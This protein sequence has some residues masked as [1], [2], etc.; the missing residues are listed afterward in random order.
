MRKGYTSTN[1]PLDYLVDDFVPIS[2]LQHYAFCERQCALIHVEQMWDDNELTVEGTQLHARVDAGKTTRRTAGV[3]WRSVFVRSVT[4]GVIGIV[5]SVE[6]LEGAWFPVE[7]KRGKRVERIADDVQ[8]CA[9]AVAL[10]EMFDVTIESGAVVYL[11]SQRRRAVAFSE[12]LR[13][14]TAAV[15][16][17]VHRVLAEMRTPVVKPAPRC[18]RCSLHDVCMPEVV[19]R[20]GA[21]E[22]YVQG[23]YRPD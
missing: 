2:A 15:A 20:P 8:L 19:S 12:S 10:E 22:A 7:Y 13:E 1:S 21:V 3:V 14:H 5:D 17:D 16:R 18:R 6:F 23:L 11:A 4:L 9:Q